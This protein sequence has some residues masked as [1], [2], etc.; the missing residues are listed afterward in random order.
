MYLFWW[1]LIK[2]KFGIY[3][4][5]ILG[6]ERFSAKQFRYLFRSIIGWREKWNY[7]KVLS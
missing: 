1:K 2:T 3:F 4:E 5:Q 6:H 7:F